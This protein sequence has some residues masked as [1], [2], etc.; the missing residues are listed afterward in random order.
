MVAVVGFLLRV[1]LVLLTQPEDRRLLVLDETFAHVSEEYLPAVSG[2][3]RDLVEETG[4]QIIMV[5]HQPELASAADKVYRVSQK[6][7]R[8]VVKAV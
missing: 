8:T 4:L 6:D 1:T 3:L 5:T 7:A 2:F